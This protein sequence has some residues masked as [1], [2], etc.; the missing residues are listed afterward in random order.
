MAANRSLP[1]QR[2]EL[3]H[4]PLAAEVVAVLVPAVPALT[5]LTLAH[6]EMTQR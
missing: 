3:R 4:V 2:L 6:C 5:S 1:L